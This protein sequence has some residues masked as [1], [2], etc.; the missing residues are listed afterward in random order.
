M[1]KLSFF[2]WKL[3]KKLFKRYII[4]YLCVFLIPF[5]IISFVWYKTSKESLENQIDLATKNYLLQVRSTFLMNFSQL[6]LLAKDLGSNSKITP[7]LIDDPYYSLEAMKEMQH[8]K[9]ASNSIEEM[10]I[11]YYDQANV[12]YSSTGSADFDA[13]DQF[14]YHSYDFNKKHLY[15]ALTSKAPSFQLFP[16]LAHK[17][18]IGLLAYIVPLASEDGSTYG[19][20]MYTI[21]PSVTEN[22]LAKAIDKKS[23]RVFIIGENNVVLSS[24]SNSDL[25]NYFD[26]PKKIENVLSKETIQTSTGTIQVNT[27]KDND[28]NLKFVALTNL[29]DV[30]HEL[31]RTNHIVLLII[32]CTIVLGVFL[33]FII[34]KRQYTPIKKLESLLSV[35]DIDENEIVMLDELDRVEYQISNFLKENESL[36]QNILRQ[37]PYAREQVIRRILMGRFLNEE[38]MELLLESVDMHLFEEKYFVMLIDTKMINREVDIENQVFLMNFLD[39]IAG[40]GFQAYGTELVSEQAIALLV[41][42]DDT[43]KQKT[44]VRDIERKL[45]SENTISPII[46]VGSIVHDIK[47]MNRTYIEALAAIQSLAISEMKKTIY[48]YNEIAQNNNFEFSYPKDEKLKLT[49]SL[50]KGDFEIAI[51]T[52]EYLIR[53]TKDENLDYVK[54]RL[55]GFDLLN[56]VLEVGNETVGSEIFSSVEEVVNFRNLSELNLPLVKM[57]KCICEFT[58][59]NVNSQ[60]SELNQ[61]I[62]AYIDAHFCS[63]EISLETIVEEFDISISYLSRFIKQETGMSFSKYVQHKRLEHIK[64]ELIDTDK[65]IKEIILSS[66]YY[67]VSNYTRKF[68]KVV[69]LTPGQFRTKNR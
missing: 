9:V 37:I 21:K 52:I 11:Y 29:S 50:R 30:F 12:L 34:G 6:D 42:M 15:D 25:P 61:T 31:N 38:Q 48:Y 4:F 16:S 35:K 28:Y 64:S 46:G 56:T 26:T 33:I 60:E 55:Y 36:H 66:G 43:I 45:I 41:S 65:P 63:H 7:K 5:S 67:D 59:K 17:N 10:Y 54:V 1:K 44:I 13:F 3:K 20:V 24:S 57:S 58:K 53:R 32:G 8:Y 51:E 23:G 47:N 49:Q 27:L 62:L 18:Q 19:S 40:D 68:K 2:H 14:K 69:G 39:D 22:M